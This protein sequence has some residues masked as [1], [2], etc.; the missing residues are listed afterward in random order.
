MAEAV[1]VPLGVYGSKQGP[2]PLP[3]LGSFTCPRLHIFPLIAGPTAFA[4]LQLQDASAPLPQLAADHLIK[5]GC[6]NDNE[7]S[8]TQAQ[9]IKSWL[10]NIVCHESMRNAPDQQKAVQ[11][12]GN[13]YPLLR[14]LL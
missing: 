4:G 11:T 14:A 12:L 3:Q 1:A 9:I 5:R 8:H 13:A 2:T 6:S 10:L 7:L